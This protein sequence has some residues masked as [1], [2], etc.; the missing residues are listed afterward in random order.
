MKVRALFWYTGRPERIC[1]EGVPSWS[2]D[3]TIYVLPTLFLPSASRDHDGG[4]NFL[5]RPMFRFRQLRMI[6]KAGDLMRYFIEAAPVLRAILTASKVTF[7]RSFNRCRQPCSCA[8]SDQNEAVL[9]KSRIPQRKGL[10]LDAFSQGFV[11]PRRHRH[12]IQRQ[13]APFL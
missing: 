2:L 9:I 10:F 4:S 13:H 11:P 6:F 5:R 1:L 12:D 7:W 8:R 3:A